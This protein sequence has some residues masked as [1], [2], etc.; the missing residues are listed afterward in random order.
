VD[1][2]EQL[3]EL[4]LTGPVAWDAA[5]NAWV[6][7]DYALVVE[8]MRDAR[9]FTVDDPRFST[10]Q[11]LGPSMLSLDGE[12]HR[13]HRAPF[14]GAF[15][16]ATLRGHL[17]ERVR[18]FATDRL[19]AL[20]D[21]RQRSVEIRTG[22]AG[23][24]AAD[25]MRIA[26][27]L[28][29]VTSEEL[30]GWYRD[31]VAAVSAL[32][33]GS[34]AR[35]GHRAAVAALSDAISVS[36]AVDG[37]MLAGPARELSRSEVVSNTAVCLFGGIETAEGMITNLFAHLLSHPD[38]NRIASDPDRL[39][40][41]VD[42]SLR[43]EPSVTRLDRFA[44]EDVTVSQARIKRGDMVVLSIAGANRDPK[45]FDN[46]HAYLPDRPNANKHVT[47]AQGPH[48]CIAMH[49]SRLEA[50]TAFE[51][52]IGILAGLRLAGPLTDGP[53]GTVFRKWEQLH[54]VWGDSVT[55]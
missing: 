44:T 23:P 49:L 17:A 54:A 41:A 37:A 9:R 42:E 35:D 45:V 4:R 25:V 13:R 33:N 46:P 22:L 39:Y 55:V 51:T 1:F 5:I 6:V 14:A 47:F 50:A 19:I 12:E 18:E 36:L 24:L 10:G 8:W 7:T 30:L 26:L 40:V 29:H 53:I 34:V 21:S 3:A 31:I 38:I 16:A 52:A 48:A 2:H 28:D 32:S 20:R 43:L 27:G 15:G 11:V